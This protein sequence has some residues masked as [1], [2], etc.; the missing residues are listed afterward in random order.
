[1]VNRE[2]DGFATADL[3]DWPEAS[4][5]CEVENFFWKFAR[6]QPPEIRIEQLG[7]VGYHNAGW[8]YFTV[9]CKAP[10]FSQAEEILAQLYD[11]TMMKWQG[12]I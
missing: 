10:S 4:I 11:F 2:K 9:I 5:P 12:L 7:G 6:R 1:M 3:L 8:T